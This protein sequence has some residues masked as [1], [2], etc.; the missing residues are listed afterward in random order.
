M[1]RAAPVTSALGALDFDLS[2]TDTTFMQPESSRAILPEPPDKLK[3]MSSRLVER[4]RGEIEASGPIPFSEYMERALYEPGL[5]YY[6]AGLHKLGGSGD[7]VT[8]PE[9]GPA[10]AQCLARQI[11]QIADTLGEYEILE[12][13][14]GTGR[15]A[16][17]LLKALE[18]MAPPR[19]YRILERSADMRREQEKSLADALPDMASRIDWLDTPPSS[20]WDG[21]MLANEVVDALPVERFELGSNGIEQLCVDTEDSGLTCRRRPAPPPLETTV[22]ARLGERL[23]HMP[24]GYRSEVCLMLEPWLTEVSATLTRG[25][26]LLIDYGYPREA[27]YAPER[28][29]GTLICHFRH[30]GHDDPFFFPGL[31]DISAFVD[32]TALAEAGK[33]ASFACSGYASQAMFLIGCGLEKILQKGMSLP[34]R[35]RLAF[36]AQ[37]RELTLPSAMGE[38][39]QVMALT[40]GLDLQ[41]RGFAPQDLRHRL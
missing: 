32:F 11:A 17:D 34:D 7:F 31:Q 12:I 27:Y 24:E 14:A 22:R 15:L 8:A 23:E 28:R 6:S 3:Q 39:F 26:A 25:C 29:D 35:Q 33:A 16:I 41:L 9:L 36:A 30:R 40:R 21:V 2:L 4:I 18:Q 20:G 37:V 13:G 5:G 1:R 19:R 38:K 10:F